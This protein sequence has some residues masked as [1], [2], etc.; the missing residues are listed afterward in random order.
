MRGV[1]N[2]FGGKPLTTADPS[3]SVC[4]LRF[5]SYPSEALDALR[6]TL[7]IRPGPLG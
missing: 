4:A 3:V 5:C 1:L 7:G 6:F 2:S